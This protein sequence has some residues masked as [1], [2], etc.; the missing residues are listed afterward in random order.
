MAVAATWM[1]LEIIILSEV[2]QT[3]KDKHHMV[4]LICGIH[5]NDAK[6]LIN[7]METKAQILKSN[8]WL[9]KGKLWG[10]RISWKAGVNTYTLRHTLYTHNAHY[11]I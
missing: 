1:D 7:K 3:E 2:I 5:K 11:C 9:P 8:F 10:G 4:S 6:E